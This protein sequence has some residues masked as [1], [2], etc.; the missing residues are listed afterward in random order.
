MHP[1]QDALLP[2]RA[3]LQLYQYCSGQQVNINKGAFCALSRVM[4]TQLTLVS[5]TLGGISAKVFH[6]DI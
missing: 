5:T 3:F 1:L 4:D 2:I 6:S